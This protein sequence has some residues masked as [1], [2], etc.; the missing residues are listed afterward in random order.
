MH[1]SGN[2]IFGQKSTDLRSFD[3]RY[4]AL[5]INIVEKAPIFAYKVLLIAWVYTTIGC[6]SN[7]IREL[8]IAFMSKKNTATL[9]TSDT[10]NTWL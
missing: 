10:I 4:S 2:V 6:N 9:E 5:D 1:Q 8:P 3:W 7:A